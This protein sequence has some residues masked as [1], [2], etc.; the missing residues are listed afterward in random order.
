[1][2]EFVRTA[3]PV[4]PSVHVIQVEHAE[5]RVVYAAPSLREK[6]PTLTYNAPVQHQDP[7]TGVETGTR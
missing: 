1:M 6:P 7:G 2:K 3:G 4:I 5:K